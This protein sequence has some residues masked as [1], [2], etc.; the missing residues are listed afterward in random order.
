MAY[1]P[2]AAPFARR[3]FAAPVSADLAQAKSARR[4]SQDEWFQKIF[5]E[6]HVISNA[7]KSRE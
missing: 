7:K 1:V 2:A 5:C 4:S 6:A 3:R